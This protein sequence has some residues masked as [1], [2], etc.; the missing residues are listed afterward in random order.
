[1]EARLCCAGRD[2]AVL[3]ADRVVRS[4]PN[5]SNR[6]ASSPEASR[7]YNKYAE[8]SAKLDIIIVNTVVQL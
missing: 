4:Q 6:R 7:V 2:E 3:W 1:M 5:T 8:I